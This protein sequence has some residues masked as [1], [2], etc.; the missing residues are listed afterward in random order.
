MIHVTDSNGQPRAVTAVYHVDHN[1][2]IRPL[3]HLDDSKGTLWMALRCCFSSG[4]WYENMQWLDSE[5]W[6][7]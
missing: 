6:K 3:S 2:T 1:K 7:E 5:P 4:L